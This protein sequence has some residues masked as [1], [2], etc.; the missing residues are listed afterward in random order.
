M[1]HNMIQS[2]IFPKEKFDQ[3]KAEEWLQSH[4]FRTTFRKKGVDITENFYRY[5]QKD[6]NQ[7]I[8]FRTLVLNNGIQF[9]VGFK[10]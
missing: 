2:V 5:R 3:K 8:R 7:F 4:K 9:I 6:P 1:V 10:N